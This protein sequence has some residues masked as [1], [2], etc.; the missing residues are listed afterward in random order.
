MILNEKS[1]IIP[2]RSTK[3]SKQDRIERR[4]EYRLC[5]NKINYSGVTKEWLKS[6]K[7]GRLNIPC[8]GKYCKLCTL[9]NKERKKSRIK[10]NRKE[11]QNTCKQ[12]IMLE[13]FFFRILAIFFCIF[14]CFIV[15]Y[16]YN[17]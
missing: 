13:N 3:E 11:L 4:K 12:F 16:I 15:L 9:P 17:K 5:I 1:L 10:N 2:N 7:Y 6:V 14:Y 8:G